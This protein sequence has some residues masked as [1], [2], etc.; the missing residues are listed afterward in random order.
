[1]VVRSVSWEEKAGYT[2]WMQINRLEKIDNIWVALEMQVVRRKG[3]QLAHKT[4]LRF[5]N[6][7]FNQDL[8]EAL[9]TTRRLE[10]GL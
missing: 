9:F 6:V 7:K 2:K 10:K 1:M 8:D 5:D 3:K 4:I